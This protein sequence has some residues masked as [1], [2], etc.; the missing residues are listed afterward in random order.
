MTDT[1]VSRQLQQMIKFIEFEAKTKEQ[2]IRTNAEQE[3]EREKATYI[4]KERNKLEADYQRRVKEA[5]VKKKIT[6]SQEL[7]ES[8]LQL[9][10]AEDKHIQ[11]LMESVRNKLTESVKNDTYQELLIKLIQEGIKKVEDNEVTI[12]CLKVE[13][14]KVKKAIEIVKKM[15]SS[16]KIQVD[17]K[18]FLEP[19]VIGGV[20]VVSY[21][22]KIVCN[23]TLE[24]R[25]NAALTVALPLIRKTVFPSLK[26]QTQKN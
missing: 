20:S 4:E 18:N 24:Y 14:D 22:D 5:E 11:T 23:N 16:L 17:D 7:S 1:Q 6:F 9:L 3:C 8:R 21:G 2:E 19:T 26:N 12:R 15:D 10:E 25:M 13:L